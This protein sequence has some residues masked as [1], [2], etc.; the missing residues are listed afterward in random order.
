MNGA[1]SFSP[2]G[3]AF[4]LGRGGDRAMLIREVEAAF[5]VTWCES[6]TRCGRTLLARCLRVKHPWK[7]GQWHASFSQFR[8][9]TFLF[10]KDPAANFAIPFA[11]LGLVN[12][13]G[14]QAGIVVS[15]LSDGTLVASMRTGF[16]FRK[17]D[18]RL[19]AYVV[20]PDCYKQP[21]RPVVLTNSLAGVRPVEAGGQEM[22]FG[23]PGKTVAND[24][25]LPPTRFQFSEVAGDDDCQSLLKVF[26][27]NV[28]KD[29]LFRFFLAIS[30]ATADSPVVKNRCLWVTKEEHPMADSGYSDGLLA[31]IAEAR[32]EKYYYQN[33]F[34]K[35]AYFRKFELKDV[36]LD[37]NLFELYWKVLP[38]A[39]REIL[40]AAAVTPQ[41]LDSVLLQ[42]IT[43]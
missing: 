25:I 8:D 22:L 13:T 40:L 43:S 14:R 15:P 2:E 34:C 27:T 9:V 42:A 28:T 5:T 41:V 18:W 24:C 17:N 33:D 29:T 26:S 6:P 35:N 4:K 16:V 7:A 37:P 23:F 36:F 12:Y 20:A 39:P 10:S 1:F 11:D 21:V 32:M 38:R 19:T 30:P 31:A 3:F